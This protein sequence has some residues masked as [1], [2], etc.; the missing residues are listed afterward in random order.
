MTATGRPRTPA[1]MRKRRRLYIVLTG[2]TML[3][4]AAA[5]V[6]TALEDNIVFFHSPSDIQAKAIARAST[7]AWVGW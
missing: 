4:V 5:L 7:S 2:L 1:A 3:G 6:L